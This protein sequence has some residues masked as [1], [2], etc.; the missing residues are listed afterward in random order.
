LRQPGCS[1]VCRAASSPAISPAE[2]YQIISAGTNRTF[3]QGGL[4]SP[5]NAGMIGQ[6]GQDDQ[7]SFYRNLMGVGE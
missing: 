7:T 5:T 6:A 4:W 2:N 3:G 1:A